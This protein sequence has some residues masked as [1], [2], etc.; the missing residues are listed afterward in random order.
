MDNGTNIAPLTFLR[1][2]YDN[3]G[4][5]SFDA[6]GHHP[7]HYPYEVKAPGDW[8]AFSGVTPKLH[9]LMVS[10]GDSTKKIWG[11]EY[12][13]PTG[14]STQSVSEQDQV[15][16]MRDGYTAWNDWTWTGPLLWY[17]WRNDGTDPAN[18]EH[19]FG[20]IRHDFSAKPSLA[21][22][23]DIAH[24]QAATTPTTAAPTT[25]TT[26]PRG[27]HHHRCSGTHDHHHRSGTHHHHHHRSACVGS[28][29]R[30]GHRI[31]VARCAHRRVA[32]HEGEG[33]VRRAGDVGW[34]VPSSDPP[35]R[36]R[37]RLGQWFVLRGPAGRSGQSDVRVPGL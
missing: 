5:G 22:Y 14:S 9:D 36:Q 8:N 6:V 15:R 33:P 24:Q 11:T 12:G 27:T 28:I 21:A 26:T 18:R 20:L 13:I 23:T 2:I 3:G 25:P 4:G 32:W 16:L 30:Q 31:A 10:R 29:P 7:Y 19:H 34:C 35:R 37:H 1:A 17:N